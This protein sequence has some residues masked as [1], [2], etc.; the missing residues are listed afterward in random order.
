MW[1]GWFAA[2]AFSVAAQRFGAHNLQPPEP[3]DQL[4]S[5][6]E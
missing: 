6:D 1:S 4:G 3:P 2:S 5:V